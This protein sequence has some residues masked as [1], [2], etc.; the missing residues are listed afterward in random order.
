VSLDDALAEDLR[1]LGLRRAAGFSWSASARTLLAELEGA[2]RRE[3]AAQAV[4]PE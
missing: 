2:A 1:R 3:G 4:R